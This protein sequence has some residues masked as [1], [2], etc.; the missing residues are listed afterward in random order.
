MNRRS[1]LATITV[2]AFLSAACGG[3][4]ELVVRDAWVRA[5]PP[6]ATVMAAYLSLDNQTA[7]DVVLSGASSPQFGH[8]MI[9]ATEVVDG[10][11]RM[12]HADDIDIAAGSS[13]DLTPGGYHLML[14]RPLEPL[15][16]GAPVELTLSFADGNTLTVQTSVK[17]PG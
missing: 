3:H 17:A 9:H 1:A 13:F 7:A 12:R 15:P 16:V 14:M 2:M 11:A 8:V 5:A 6:G 10:V 4:D